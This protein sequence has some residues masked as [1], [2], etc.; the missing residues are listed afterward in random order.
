[1]PRELKWMRL[2]NAAKIFPAIMRRDWNNVFRVSALLKEEVDPVVLQQ[3]VEDVLPR[4]PSMAVR[5]RRGAFWYYLEQVPKAP[6]V[7]QDGA[8]PLIHMYRQELRT[9]ALRVLYYKN[10]IAVE[11]FHAVTDGNGGM[12]FLK[13][14]TARYLTLRY[15]AEITPGFG[16]LDIREAPAAEEL[17]DSFQKYAAPVAMSRAEPNAYHL[18]GGT[19]EADGFRHLIT[20]TVDAKQLKEAAHKYGVTV[21]AF[22]SAVMVQVIMEMQA[23]RRRPQKNVQISVPVNLRPLYGSRTLRNFVL[24]IN[25]G[26][27]PRLGNYDLQ[28]LCTIMGQRIAME[29]TPKLMSARIA[30]NV[31]AERS[32]LLKVT[33][34]FLKNLAMRLVYNSVGETK[35]SITISNLGLQKLPEE[36]APYVTRLDFIIGVQMSYHNNCSVVSYGGVTAINMIRSIKEPELE[37][38]FFTRLVELGLDVTL[39][40]NGE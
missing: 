18:R 38:R 27:D 2:D 33:P 9:C 14:L 30:A 34:L 32:A 24:N 7:R 25:P 13:T 23:Q 6:R 29:V 15:G 36:M 22:L 17:E 31:N 3:A 40:S 39:E 1:M 5:L 26:V 19:P 4:F 8:Y 12:V 37:R 28:E 21:T 11:I 10:R 16:V 20:G 35:N